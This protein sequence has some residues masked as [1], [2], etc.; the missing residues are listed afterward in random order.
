VRA[1]FDLLRFDLQ[2]FNS[3]L[4]SHTPQLPAKSL[5]PPIEPAA[6]ASFITSA[7][8]A[9]ALAQEIPLLQVGGGGLK[10]V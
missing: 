5:P 6:Q 2:R 8:E 7:D 3:L 1:R 9:S 4:A 10:I